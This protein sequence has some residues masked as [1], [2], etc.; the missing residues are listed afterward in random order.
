MRDRVKHYSVNW[1][2]G[3]KINKSHFISQDEAYKDALQDVA[4]LNLSPLRYGILPPSFAAENT[5][6][7]KIS[8]DNQN[9]LRATVLSCQAITPGGVRINLP[10]LS[11]SGLSDTDG[12]PAA[13]FQLQASGNENIW[14]IVLY[15]HPFEKQPAGSPD[16][17][18]NPPRFPYILPTYSVQ[19][20]S[21]SQY[22][23]FAQHPYA[24]IIGK[25]VVNGS[26]VRVEENYIPPCF[27]ISANSDLVTL[28]AELDKFLA[29]LETLC[30][31]IVQKIFVKKQQND[32]SE[33]VLFL[34][35]RMVLYL[36]QAI[37]NVRWTMMHESPA[38]LFATVANLARVMKNTID[39]RIG[40]GKEEMMNYF[41]D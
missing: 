4:A 2:D 32:I 23:Q 5:F 28:H 27:S 18:E 10:A 34:C 11:M 41:S 9:T 20:L 33:L 26:E 13:S 35:D 40:S 6:N 17:S 16:L 38:A 14:W 19:V 3:M 24:L 36:A 25:A 37:T 29:T 30:S 12:V 39:L 22:A 8:V 15:V 21:E 1:I 31:K 7:L